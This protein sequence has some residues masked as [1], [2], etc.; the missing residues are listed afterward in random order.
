MKWARHIKEF[1]KVANLLRKFK[2]SLETV[3][4]EGKTE[5]KLMN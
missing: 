4:T 1:G 5:V 3:G 2:E